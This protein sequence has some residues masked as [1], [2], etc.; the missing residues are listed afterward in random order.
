MNRTNITV[1]WNFSH[2]IFN[3]IPVLNRYHWM[4]SFT[5][6]YEPTNLHEQANGRSN[7]DK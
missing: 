6:N 5:A 4:L 1:E 3:V 2:F 7:A